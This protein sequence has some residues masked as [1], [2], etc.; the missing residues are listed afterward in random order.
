M[1]KELEVNRTTL[2]ECVSARSLCLKKTTV[3]ARWCYSS[4][5][6]DNTGHAA[7]VLGRLT[8]RGTEFPYRTLQISRHQTPTCGDF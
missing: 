8:S 2:G 6:R 1:P 3:S 7:A 4:L 5:S